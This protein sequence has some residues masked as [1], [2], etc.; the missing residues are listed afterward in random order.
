MNMGFDMKGFKIKIF[1]CLGVF[2]LALVFSSCPPSVSDNIE[3]P[4]QN[5]TKELPGLSGTS[6]ELD[7]VKLEFKSETEVTMNG[8]QSYSYS[9]DRGNRIGNASTLGDFTVSEDSL[10]LEF[11]NFMGSGKAIFD[12]SAREIIVTIWFWGQGVLS[13]GMA[14]VTINGVAYTYTYDRT[15]QT[16]T[17]EKIG[18]FSLGEDELTIQHW[19]GSSFDVVFSKGTAPEWNGSLVGTA[20]GWENAFNGWMIFEFMTEDACILTFTESTYNDDTPFE[21][22]YTF[23]SGTNTGNILTQGTFS[24]G[25]NKAYI[26]FAQW[27]EYPHGA[28]FNRIK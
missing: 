27:R 7:G 21:Y 14:K 17:I 22:G 4:G 16:G 25:E 3:N 23:N 2:F 9:Y 15:V 8:T 10:Q 11:P 13:F 19:R 26:S 1:F 6:W 12:N 18:S 5:E 20:W 24:V 28:V